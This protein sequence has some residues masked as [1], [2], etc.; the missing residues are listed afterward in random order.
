MPTDTVGLDAAEARGRLRVIV[1]G[2]SALILTIGLA[3]FSYTPLLPVM[4]VQAGL[5]YAAGGWLATSNYLGYIAGVLLAASIADLECKFRLYR[6]CLVLAV[7]T[8]MAMG[9]TTNVAL[10]LVLRFVSGAASIGGPLLSSGLVLNW[11]MRHG[12]RPELGLHFTGLGLGI[13]L[14][15]LAVAAMSAHLAWDAQW[16]AFGVLGLAFFVPAWIW[17]PAPGPVPAAHAEAY[18]RPPSRSWMWLL[19]GAYFCAGW[20]FVTSGTFI[21]A[22]LEKLPTFAGRGSW[23]WVALGLAATPSAFLWDRIARAIDMIPALLLAYALQTLSIVIPLLT[24]NLASN[25]LGAMLFGSTF[26][27]IVSLMLALIGRCF[28][29]NPAKAMARLTISYGI[30]QTVAPALAALLATTAGGYRGSL[31]I[32]GGVMAIGVVLIAIIGARHGAGAAVG[33]RAG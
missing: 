7:A 21:V 28:P 29:E 5:S 15:G 18:T 14:S 33:E 24:A 1:A 13:V 32:A 22:I 26:V 30:A 27:G 6:L 8:T 4:R 2:I 9:L 23:T 16:I 11:L 3:R 25:L 17:L 10:W 12:R 19:V 31:G 20:G